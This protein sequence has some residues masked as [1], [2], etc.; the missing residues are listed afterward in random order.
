VGWG[1]GRSSWFEILG[2][3]FEEFRH[4]EARKLGLARTD[5]LYLTAGS[6]VK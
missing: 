4:H 1:R 6:P 3:A 5:P 2:A